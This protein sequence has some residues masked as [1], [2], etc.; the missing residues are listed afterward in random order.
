MVSKMCDIRTIRERSALVSPHSPNG[1]C[2]GT[3]SKHS[4]F[5]MGIV[6]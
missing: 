3:Q 6:L 5:P 2:A 4:A 1:K